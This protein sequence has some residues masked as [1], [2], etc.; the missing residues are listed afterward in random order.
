MYSYGSPHMATQKQD[1]QHERTFSSYVRIQVVVLKTYLGRWT[2]GRSGERGSGISVLPARYDDDDDDIYIYIYIYIFQILF[3]SLSI[4]IYRYP[5]SF[6]GPTTTIYIYI[7]IYIL[8]TH[9]IIN[10][11]WYTHSNIYILYTHINNGCVIN[12]C[13]CVIITHMHILMYVCAWNLSI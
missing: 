4:Y 13:A 7:Y 9:Y 8:H 1:D 11:I 3:L 5:Y 10:N 2:I 12:M 6:F